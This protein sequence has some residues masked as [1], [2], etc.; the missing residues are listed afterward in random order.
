MEC[1]R[2]PLAGYPQRRPGAA[3]LAW[4]HGCRAVVAGANAAVFSLINILMFPMLPVREPQQLV[5]FLVL[6]PGDPPLNV[7]SWHRKPWMEKPARNLSSAD[8]QVD[9]LEHVG[10]YP[11]EVTVVVLDVWRKILPFHEI[12]VDPLLIVPRAKRP[13]CQEALGHPS[14]VFHFG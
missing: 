8:F 4:V 12:W 10:Q 5:E 6:Y 9:L 13:P 14:L 3:A 7:F 2:K 1:T 11:H